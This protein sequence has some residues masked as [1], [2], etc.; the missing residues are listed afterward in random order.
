MTAQTRKS[1]PPN[2]FSLISNEKLLALYS[3]LLKCSMMEERARILL[4][5]RKLPISCLGPALQAAAVGVA[6]DLFPEDT[7]ITFPGD[8]V[9]LFVKG[10][11]L[12]ELVRRLLNPASPPPTAA[13]QLRLAAS[14]A[15][16]HKEEKS[17]KLV[18]VFNL[19]KTDSQGSWSRALRSAGAR[20]LPIVFVS[21][22]SLPTEPAN[23]NPRPSKRDIALA[24]NPFGFPAIAVD[25]SD[26][27]AVYRVACEAIAHARKGNGPTLIEPAN[28]AP[29]ADPILI[30]EK[31]LASKNLFSQEWKLKVLAGFATELDNAVQM[32]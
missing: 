10:L 31:Y 15:L 26:V 12:G 1:L 29:V 27:V 13:A 4:K 6:I 23:S 5:K 28:C 8:L 17:G 19:A 9:S 7:V 11:P 25:G 24:A 2:G 16:A 20:N 22:K 18:V 14:A 3:N 30:M 32:G 21:R